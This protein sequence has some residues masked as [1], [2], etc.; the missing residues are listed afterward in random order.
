MAFG[1]F[2]KSVSADLILY[3]GIILTQN[4]E[5]PQVSAVACTDGEIIATGDFDSMEDLIDGHTETVDLNGKY[6]LPGLIDTFSSHVMDIFKGKY[7]DLKNCSDV[8]SL[9]SELAS[10]ISSNPQAEVIFGY[11]YSEKILG[12]NPEESLKDIMA[13]L[14]ELCEDKPVVLLCAS[15]VSCLLNTM[16]SSIVQETAEE[17]VVRYIT[18]PYI[19][20]LFVPFD[21]EAIHEE[22]K[23]SI[24]RSSSLGFTSALNIGSPDYFEALYQD[25]LISLYNEDLLCRRFFGSYL[26]N[27]PLLPKGLV[28]RLLDRKTLCNEIGDLINAKI[29]NVALDSSSCPVDFSQDKLDMILESVA[30]KGFDI[31]ISPSG[32]ADLALAYRS[33]DHVRSKGGKQIIAIQSDFGGE[34]PDDELIYSET[35]FCALAYE[36]LIALPPEEFIEYLTVKA[37]EL[38]GMDDVL[39]TIEKGKKADM[40]VFDKNPL[41]MDAE[42]FLNYPASMTIFDGKII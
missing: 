5:N 4:P 2:K 12:D 34:T 10:W 9:K 23:D 16:A 18:V 36:Q 7:A 3:N 41:S 28:H 8:E 14:D 25:S 22:I 6:L 33:A 39:G 20:N 29:L 13:S 11:G 32:E 26:M 15:T 17:E 37:S 40:A 21:F 27:R 1:F 31:Y 38:I 24:A 19:L 30:D 35:V 42:T